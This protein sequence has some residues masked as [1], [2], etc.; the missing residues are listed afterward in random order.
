MMQVWPAKYKD[1]NGEYNTVIRNDK[2]NLRMNVRGVEFLGKGFDDFRVDED[3]SKE[4]LASFTLDKYDELSDCLIECVIPVLIISN[5]KESEA[6]LCLKLEFGKVGE[7]GWRD[8]GN[9][10]L[11]LEYQDRTFQ[12]K[13]EIGWLEDSLVEIQ[14]QLPEDHRFKNCFGCA[15]SDYSVYGHDFF[16]GMLCFR[17]KKK[18][19]EQFQP[20]MIL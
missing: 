6:K 11:I 7:K 10:T 18:L 1:K 17:N 13:G 4:H 5:Q 8:E 16:G 3:L 9:L 19:T 2:T 15:F 20:R 12:S 14:K